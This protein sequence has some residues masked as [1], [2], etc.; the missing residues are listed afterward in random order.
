MGWLDGCAL[1][2]QEK[3]GMSGLQKT[4]MTANW[5]RKF[6]LVFIAA[7]GAIVLGGCAR[8]RLTKPGSVPSELLVGH[9]DNAQTID[10]R[11]WPRL[12]RVTN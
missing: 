11:N 7:F 6:R 3:F 5:R 12:R 2:R 4:F 10:L 1:A 9:V 8:G